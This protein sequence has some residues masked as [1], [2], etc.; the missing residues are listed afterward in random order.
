MKPDFASSD[1]VAVVTRLAT[2]LI[3]HLSPNVPTASALIGSI[4]LPKGVWSCR[5]GRCDIGGDTSGRSR[6]CCSQQSTILRHARPS[7]M[8][9]QSPNLDAIAVRPA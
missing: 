8:S 7:L 3:H 2:P 4:A 5:F 6:A 1:E 9:G